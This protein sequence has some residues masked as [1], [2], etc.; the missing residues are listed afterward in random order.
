MKLVDAFEIGLTTE[1]DDIYFEYYCKNS[2]D[3]KN[4]LMSKIQS[5]EWPFCQPFSIPDHEQ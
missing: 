3:L 5:D 1:E 2:S 4:F